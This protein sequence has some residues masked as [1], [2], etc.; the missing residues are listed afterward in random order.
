MKITS[1]TLTSPFSFIFPF[2]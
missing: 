1:R 2:H